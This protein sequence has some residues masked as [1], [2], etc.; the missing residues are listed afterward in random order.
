VTKIVYKITDRGATPRKLRKHL[1]AAKLVAWQA[2]GDRF[3]NEFRDRRFTQ[4][5]GRKA[6]YAP[7]RGDAISPTAKG[8]KRTYIGKKFTLFGHR[9]PL[10]F[11]GEVRR[12]VATKRMDVTTRSCVLRYPGAR[13]L[14]FKHPNSVVRAA[15]EF[16]RVLPSEVAE[17]SLK[18]DRTITAEMAKDVQN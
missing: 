5:H 13:K 3:H 17:I 18:I 14:N 12:E 9:R 2:A 10:E 8:W 6:G 16:M 15:D 1:T 7:R 11:T 4:S